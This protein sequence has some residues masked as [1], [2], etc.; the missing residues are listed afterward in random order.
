MV[1]KRQRKEDGSPHP[2]GPHCPVR[3][4]AHLNRKR[5]FSVISARRAYVNPVFL[6]EGEWGSGKAFDRRWY[7]N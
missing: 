1:M 3:G 7:F 2:H 4:D 5:R 6:S